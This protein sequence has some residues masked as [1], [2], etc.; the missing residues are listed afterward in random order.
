MG[1]DGLGWL[2][3]ASDF[4]AAGPKL[5]EGIRGWAAIE[6]EVIRRWPNLNAKGRGGAKA[7]KVAERDQIFLPPAAGGIQGTTVQQVQKRPSLQGFYKYFKVQQ[8][9][10][11]KCNRRVTS[12]FSFAFPVAA[13]LE[14]KKAMGYR[15]GR[16]G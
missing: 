10:N 15:G 5:S 6:S 13:A 16:A 4:G 3:K 14:D 9:C 2:Q 8:K 7:A 1:S 11:R 12:R